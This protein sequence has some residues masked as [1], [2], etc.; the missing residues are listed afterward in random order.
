MKI[1]SA[2]QINEWDQ[3]T[4]ASEPI[5]SLGLMERAANACVA[6]LLH[7][8][9]SKDFYIFCGPGNNGGDGLAIAR[10]LHHHNL[11]VSVFVIPSAKHSFDFDANLQQLPLAVSHINSANDFPEIKNN[12]III[13]ALF[14]TGLN[15]PLTG[16]VAELVTYINY[17]E[18]PIISIDMP[19]GMFADLTSCNNTVVKALH[20]LSFQ[21]NK[22]AFM[23]TENLPFTGKVQLLDIGLQQSYYHSTETDLFTIDAPLIKEIYKPRKNWVH[24]Y[25]VGHALIYAGSKTMMGAA[26][27]CSKA[28]LRAGAGLVSLHVAEAQMQ[29]LHSAIPEVIA[30]DEN[31]FRVASQKKNCIVFGPGLYVNES[32]HSLLKTILL[33]WVGNLLI[34]ASGLE[35]LKD[36]LTLLKKRPALQ[37]VLTPHAGEFDKLFGKCNNDFDRFVLAIQKAKEYGVIIVLKG[38]HTLVACPDGKAFFNTSGNSGMATAGTGDVLAGIIAGLMAQHYQAKEACILGVYLH[39][40]AGD[41]AAA[42]FSKEAMIAS[43]IIEN[44]GVA[45]STITI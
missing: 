30:T 44:L 28:C 19:S 42:H 11:M 34:D 37:T 7:H 3:F 6:W 14:G 21:C 39:G 20:T 17:A 8:Y 38:P 26:L 40:L 5:T 15:K 27:L 41:K 1:F 43:D 23:M 25:N 10:Q 13:D 29:V 32:N 16:V 33:E 35:M 45:F 2:P 18:A 36:H 24:K 12:A 4:I 22:L 31:N 9:P